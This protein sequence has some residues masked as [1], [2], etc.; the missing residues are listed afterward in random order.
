MLG[1]RTLIF[2]S[3]LSAEE[4]VPRAGVQPGALW[5]Y[6]SSPTP[7]GG[8]VRKLISVSIQGLGR[9]APHRLTYYNYR[10][11]NKEAESTGSAETMV[12]LE[13]AW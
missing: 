5:K 4:C 1:I 6:Q 12:N 9:Q 10:K 7:V 13:A 8:R 11:R 3:F 2:P